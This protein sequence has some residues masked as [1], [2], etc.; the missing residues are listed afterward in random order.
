[1]GQ[2]LIEVYMIGPF[3]RWGFCWHR[4]D[5]CGV[6]RHIS[7]VSLHTVGVRVGLFNKSDL[8]T[9]FVLAGHQMQF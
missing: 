8:K 5:L 9:Y 1:M 7:T 4:L 3:C 2:F 6:T